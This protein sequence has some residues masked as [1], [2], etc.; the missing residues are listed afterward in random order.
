MEAYLRRA[1]FGIVAVDYAADHLHVSYL[2]R[3]ARARRPTRCRIRPAVTRPVPR[4][5]LRA[6]RAAADVMR[7]SEYVPASCWPSCPARG[8][9]KGVPGR[10]CGRWPGRTLLDYTA[11]AAARSRA[12]STASCCRTDAEEI[13]DAGRAPASRC[14]SCGRRRWPP[15]DTPMLPVLRHAIDAVHADGWAPEFVVLLQPTS[16]LRR[17]R[18]R[19]RRA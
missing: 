3:L 2:C 11:E 9:S 7:P 4:D 15:D 12:W 16:P 18:A 10:T 1:G 8:G 14:R 6:E 19:R 5:P 17:A 13:A